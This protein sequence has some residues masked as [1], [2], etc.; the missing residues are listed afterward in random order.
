MKLSG[1]RFRV[2]YQL[3]GPDEA[4]ARARAEAICVE[5]TV[6]FPGDLIDDPEIR[7]GVSSRGGSSPNAGGLRNVPVRAGRCV[8]R[9][10]A[11]ETET[12]N[13]E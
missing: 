9:A 1:E 5:Q 3:T 11:K 8:V 12:E 7:P 10:L 2:V 4:D 13:R 6:E